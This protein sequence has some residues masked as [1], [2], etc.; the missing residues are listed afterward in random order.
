LSFVGTEW[1]ARE[2]SVTSSE[3]STDVQDPT[4]VSSPW[5][6]QNG[7]VNPALQPS[8]SNLRSRKRKIRQKIP[9]ASSLPPYHPDY[10]EDEQEAA[11]VSY[12]ES[13]ESGSSDGVQK[14]TANRIRRGSEGYEIR[15]E[16]RDE[17]LRRYLREVG[18]DPDRYLRYIPQPDENDELDEEDNVPLASYR[19]VKET[20]KEM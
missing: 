3:G 1:P 18:E 2:A 11:Y 17:M 20:V 15:Q 12:S 7:S 6:Y 19:V 13:E 9:G 5:T 4:S 8:N 14:L 10:R 16:N